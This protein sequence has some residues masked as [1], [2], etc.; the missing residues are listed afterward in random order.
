[1]LMTFSLSGLGEPLKAPG[2]TCALGPSQGPCLLMTTEQKK[3]VRRAA[4]S[5][6]KGW[7]YVGRPGR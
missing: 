2:T 3:R 4:G 5:E 1:M 6:N 7:P